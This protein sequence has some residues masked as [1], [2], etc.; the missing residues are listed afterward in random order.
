MARWTDADKV[1][2][3]KLIAQL[4]ND[5]WPEREEAWKEIVKNESSAALPLIRKARDS[6]APEV[7]ALAREIGE[8]LERKSRDLVE[9]LRCAVATRQSARDTAVIG[10]LIAVLNSDD[11][12]VRRTAQWGL[13]CLTGQDFG[14]VA[15]EE[16]DKR[17]QAGRKAQE[18]WDRNK[19]A[20]RFG[21]DLFAALDLGG[22]VELKEALIPAGEFLMG[23]PM[24]E[25]N[26]VDN[27]GPQHK[28]TI[29]KPFY[30]GIYTVTQEQYEQLM[31]KNPSNFKGDQYPV[32]NVS[33]D[34][35]VEFCKKL[36]TRTGKRVRLPTEAEWEYACRAGSK[37]RFYYGD[38]ANYVSLA[39]Y[40]WY[41]KNS[42][43]KTHPAG[44]K[45]PNDWGL[46]DMHGNVWQ[47]CSDRF[48]GYENKAK[49]DPTGPG[50]DSYWFRVMRGGTWTFDPMVC[51]SAFRFWEK[52]DFR[53]IVLGFRVAQDLN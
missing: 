6:N 16:P 53:S 14:Y 3:E 41:D 33:W 11:L 35:A 39:D 20:F 36:S 46:F 21:P 29:S 17:R 43:G 5:K 51:R 19:P 52:H 12:A 28:V 23:S 26:R 49:I 1:R 48:C 24:G 13:Q 30:M 32:E 8:A 31:G 7:A 2:V 40:A 42:K 15:G 18:W 38:D 37:T 9:A 45:K 25:P 47:W 27:E 50:S 4:G 22:G 34:D 44:Q 10:D